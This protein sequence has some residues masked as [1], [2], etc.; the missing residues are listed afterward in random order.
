MEIREIP[1]HWN[2]RCDECLELAHVAIETEHGD[3]LHLCIDRARV[4]Q[5]RLNLD[6]DRIANEIWADGNRPTVSRAKGER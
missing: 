5:E 2:A 1:R 3:Q 6:L 4:L